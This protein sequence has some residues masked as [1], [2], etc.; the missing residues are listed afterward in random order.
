MPTAAARTH[1]VNSSREPVRATCQSSQ[2]TSRRPTTSIRAM[3][4]GDLGQREA[5]G[6]CQQVP[7]PA[8]SGALPPSHAGERRQQHQHQDHGEVLDHQPAHGDPAVDRVEQA[9]GSRAPRSST[10]VLATESAR[11]KT[12]PA[13]RLQPQKAAMPSAQRRGD[14]D[15]HERARQRDRRTASRSSSEK[16]RPTPNIS[17]MTPISASWRRGR[18]RRRSRA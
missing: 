1:R 12:R 17:S 4:S 15:L 18:R 13:P 10:T 3:N 2:G 5:E 16:C 8:P 14:G 7:R 9:A 6:D 11:P